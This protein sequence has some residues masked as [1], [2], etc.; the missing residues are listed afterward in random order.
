M[1]MKKDWNM[2]KERLVF[3]CLGFLFAGTAMVP[4]GG[5]A[6]S[7]NQPATTQE[8]TAGYVRDWTSDGTRDRL[9]MSAV[10]YLGN[11][12]EPYIALPP[13]ESGN[14]DLVATQFAFAFHGYPEPEIELPK[15]DRLFIA[16]DPE[17]RVEKALL[18]TTND[19]ATIRTLAIFHRSCVGPKRFDETAKKITTCPRVPT[20]TFFVHDHDKLD[21][22]VEA[23]VVHWVEAFAK[24]NNTL[25]EKLSLKTESQFIRAV[26]VSVRRIPA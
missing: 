12:A 11:V 14:K 20:L 23:E 19:R 10:K 16:A 24:R 26:R 21:E 15:G 5:F 25:V 6:Q 7:T 17:S 8:A 1:A 18:V 4:M 9:L 13:E 3:T 2:K 22:G